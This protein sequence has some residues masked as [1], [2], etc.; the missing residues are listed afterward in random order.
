MYSCYL[1][2]TRL[3]LHMSVVTI[4]GVSTANRQK[5]FGVAQWSLQGAPVGQ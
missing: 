2:I 4:S 5:C 1:C 3:D